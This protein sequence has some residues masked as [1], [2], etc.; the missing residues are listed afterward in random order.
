MDNTD[1]WSLRGGSGLSTDFS[2]K[3]LGITASKQAEVATDKAKEMA[4]SVIPD[5]VEETASSI[6][7][8]ISNNLPDKPTFGWRDVNQLIGRSIADRDGPA[9]PSNPSLD[10]SN[11]K[12]KDS[13]VSSSSLWPFASAA[14][15]SAE[16]DTKKLASQAT[17]NSTKESLSGLA[18]IANWIVKR[19][20]LPLGKDQKLLTSSIVPS[21]PFDDILDGSSSQISEKPKQGKSSSST[22]ERSVSDTARLLF[23]S[24]PSSSAATKPS[25]PSSS[26]SGKNSKKFN[27]ERFY[28]ALC[29]KLYDEGL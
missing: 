19:I 20:P 14:E 6:S 22:R 18:G 9:S 23:G 24:S 3:K 13:K 10:S 4:S 7:S 26:S 8:S 28:V 11:N 1:H 5:S 16:Q 29:K 2:V 12:Q 21:F 27:H 25:S 17:S 15:P